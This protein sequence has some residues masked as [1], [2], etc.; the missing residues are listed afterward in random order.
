M[1][2]YCVFSL[3]SPHRGDSNKYRQY[4]IFITKMKIILNNAKSAAMEFKNHTCHKLW[5][6]ICEIRQNFKWDLI[7][8]CETW[9]KLAFKLPKGI[10]KPLFSFN[11]LSID[12][13]QCDLCLLFHKISYKFI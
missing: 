7:K 13:I 1:Q 3:E 8:F 11:K 4:T 5:T 6:E 2:V 12:T 10:L 9:T